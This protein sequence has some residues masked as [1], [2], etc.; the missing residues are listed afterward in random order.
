MHGSVRG[1]ST[2]I[3]RADARSPDR[4]GPKERGASFEH[5]QPASSAAAP[6]R[7][8][9]EARDRRLRARQDNRSFLAK[10]TTASLP[11]KG[12]RREAWTS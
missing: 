4:H 1:N 12:G 5:R 8:R 10:A 9:V 2:A 3:A 7:W 11:S 6:N